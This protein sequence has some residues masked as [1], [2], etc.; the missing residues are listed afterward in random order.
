MLKTDLLSVFAHTEFC[1]G[2]RVHAV[3]VLTMSKL[4]E[5]QP[6]REAP[7]ACAVFLHRPDALCKVKHCLFCSGFQEGCEEKHL[8]FPGIEPLGTWDLRGVGGSPLEQSALL[9]L[10]PACPPLTGELPSHSLGTSGQRIWTG[11]IPPLP[12]G[13]Q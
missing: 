5:R 10:P 2:H 6:L 7:S 3:A 13:K 9:F 8:E 12:L 1:Q 11:T 4:Q